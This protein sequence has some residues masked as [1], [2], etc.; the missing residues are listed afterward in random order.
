MSDYISNGTALVNGVINVAGAGF[1]AL[2]TFG[3]VFVLVRK[4]VG[5]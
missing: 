3:I 2:I 4:V 5:R 1:T